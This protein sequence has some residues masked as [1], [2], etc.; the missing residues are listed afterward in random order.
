MVLI[1]LELAYFISGMYL[2]KMPVFSFLF[3]LAFAPVFLLWKGCIDL[4]GLSGTSSGR[5]GRSGRA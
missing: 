5:W 4:L 3:A 1:G 2:A